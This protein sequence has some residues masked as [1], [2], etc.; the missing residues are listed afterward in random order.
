MVTGQIP[1]DSTYL[2]EIF[3]G[4]QGIRQY[5]FEVFDT[6]YYFAVGLTSGSRFL[7]NVK[8]TTKHQMKLQN[9]S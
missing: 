9:Y 4:S 3:I 7:N 2:G 6:S 5:G 1:S 8:Y